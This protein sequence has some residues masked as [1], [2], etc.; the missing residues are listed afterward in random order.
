MSND[1]DIW[2]GDLDGYVNIDAI[3]RD[4]EAEQKQAQLDRDIDEIGDIPLFGGKSISSWMLFSH[5]IMTLAWE[6]T[7]LV[8]SSPATLGRHPFNAR[9]TSQYAKK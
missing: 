5:G 6:L 1:S 4:H 8:A 3:S 9:S 7:S 2:V